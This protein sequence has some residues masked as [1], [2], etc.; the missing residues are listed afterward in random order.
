MP[1]GGNSRTSKNDRVCWKRSFPQGRSGARGFKWGI[2]VGKNPGN[3]GGK[4]GAQHVGVLKKKKRP[5]RKSRK[6]LEERQRLG[7]V[8]NGHRRNFKQ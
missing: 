6:A 8:L 4:K 5:G 1:E 3:T 7:H 2:K